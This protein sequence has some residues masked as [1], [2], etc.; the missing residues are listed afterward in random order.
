MLSENALMHIKKN[1]ELITN[2]IIKN[3]NNTW[4][5]AEFPQ[6]MFVKKKF[7][8]N[9]FVLEDNLESND[10][11][12]DYRNSVKLYENL[13]TLPRY[14]LSDER[15][16]LWLH[17]EKF[18]RIV[19]NMMKIRGK[20]TVENM[21]LHTQG[22]RRGLMFGVLS[23]CYFRVALSTDESSENKFELTR[24]VVENPL[25]FRELSWRSYSSQE[26]L[27]KGILK[28]EK[29]AIDENPGKEKNYFYPIIGKYVSIIGSVRLLDNISEKDIKDMV[30]Q[31]MIELIRVEDLSG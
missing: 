31:K 10:K 14:I 28:G 15:F 20:S 22:V 24:W 4:L 12:I 1:I 27:V 9:D 23:R 16:W 5:E 19:K 8:I 2:K 30:Y 13:K 18:Y 17:F 11:E 25:R 29:K 6:P 3:E 7:L 21:W 26:H